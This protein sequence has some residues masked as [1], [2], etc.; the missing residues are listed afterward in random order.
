MIKGSINKNLI[1]AYIR[2]I[3]FHLPATLRRWVTLNNWPF[4]MLFGLATGRIE[5][6]P[7]RESALGQIFLK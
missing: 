6:V 2:L 3:I 4:C 5:T 7:F 1:E